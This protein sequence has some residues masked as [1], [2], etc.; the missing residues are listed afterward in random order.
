MKKAYALLFAPA[1]LLGGGCGSPREIETPPAPSGGLPRLEIH[2]PAD[3]TRTTEAA[4]TVEGKSATIE[5]LVNGT[6]HTVNGQPF[7]IP[8]DLHSGMNTVII[9]AGTGYAT[10]TAVRFIERL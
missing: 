3:K 10:S 4:I 2:A 6:P 1:I 5:V 8:V 9:Q 7:K